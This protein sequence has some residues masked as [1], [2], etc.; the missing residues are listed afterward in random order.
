VSDLITPRAA[1][2][3]AVTAA[4]DCALVAAL[5]CGVQHGRAGVNAAT[6][7]WTADQLRRHAGADLT[8]LAELALRYAAPCAR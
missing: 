6:K 2:A 4:D 8:T 7:R 3:A 1:I 5:R